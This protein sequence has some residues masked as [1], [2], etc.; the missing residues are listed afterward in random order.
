MSDIPSEPLATSP[1]AAGPAGPNFEGKIGAYFLL[2]LLAQSAPVALAGTT[3]VKV[4]FQRASE[5]FPLDD[6]I[7]HAEHADG[8]AATLQIQAKRTITFA[9]QDTVFKDVVAQVAKAIQEPGFWEGQNELAVATPRTSSKITGSY[10]DVLRWAREIGSSEEFFAR[11]Q[12]PGAANADMRTFVETFRANL[13]EAGAP[14]DDLT[15]WRVLSRFHILIFDFESGGSLAEGYALEHARMLLGPERAAEAGALWSTLFDIAMTKAAA[16]GD[17]NNSTLRDELKKKGI[18][19]GDDR[20]FAPILNTI[21]SEARLALADIGTMVGTTRL[22]RHVHLSKVRDAQDTHRFVIIHG[23]AGV[24][25]SGVLRQLAERAAEDAP[26]L[27]LAPSRIEPKGFL[28]HCRRLG[29]QGT[30]ED[31]L[32]KLAAA[33]SAI[34]FIDNLDRF[35]DDE[36]QTVKDALR[37]ASQL[38]G[39]SVLATARATFGKSDDNWLP[40]EAITALGEASIP[41]TELNEDDLEEIRAAQP[42]LRPLLS[43]THPAKPIVRNLF[44]LSRIARQPTEEDVPTTELAMAA[45]WWQASEGTKST[46][47]ERQRI[48]R[49]AADAVLQGVDVVD[50][51]HQDANAVDDLVRSQTLL[52]RGSD[53]VALRHDVLREWAAANRLIDDYSLIEKLPLTRPASPILARAIELAA[54]SALERQPSTPSWQDI[55]NTVS[56]HSHHPSWRRAALLAIVNS[57]A[58]MDLLVQQS[59]ALLADD[60]K[61]LIEITRAMRAVNVLPAEIVL[62][63]LIARGLVIPKGVFIPQGNSWLPLL[64]WL[65]QSFETLPVLALK[66]V[67]DLFWDWSLGTFGL[68]PLTPYILD[69]IYPVL[70]RLKVGQEFPGQQSPLDALADGQRRALTDSLRNTFIAFCPTR[71]ALAADYLALLAAEPERSLQSLIAEPGELPKAA[72]QPFA[73]LIRSALVTSRSGSRSSRYDAVNPFSYL[74]HSFFP[75][76]DRT[77]AFASLLTHAPAIGLSLIQ[78]LVAYAVSEMAQGTPP[79]DDG[80]PL[81]IDGHNRFFPWLRTYR[82]AR[83]EGSNTVS[84]ALTA[85]RAWAIGRVQKGD[86]INVVISDVLGPPGT[87]AAFV[88][89]AIDVLRSLESLL[90]EAAIP[91]VGSP[92]LLSFERRSS[93]LDGRGPR[94]IL[95]TRAARFNPQRL[96]PLEHILPQ[97]ALPQNADARALLLNQ[98]QDAA[99]RLG[100]P[101]A[102][103]D[104]GDPR[105]MVILAINYINP[106]NWSPNPENPSQSV[107]TSPQDEAQRQQALLSAASAGTRDFAIHTQLHMALE[108]P[109]HSS[110]AFAQGV[111]EWATA[112]EAT[113]D[114]EDSHPN[115]QDR[116]R[117]AFIILRDG[118]DE[119]VQNHGA[120]AV[121]TLSNVASQPRDQLP[122]GQQLPYNDVALAF[123]GLFYAHRRNPS[124]DYIARLLRFAAT[125]PIEAG[126]G[127]TFV[128][129]DIACLDPRLSNALVRTAFAA[130]VRPRRSASFDEAKDEAARVAHT[131]ATEAH[132]LAE[133]A[134]LRNNRAEPSWPSFPIEQARKRRGIRLPS[135]NAANSQEPEPTSEPAET[136]VDER[137]AATWISL[138]YP[139]CEGTYANNVI[140]VMQA[141]QLY[142]TTR[143]GA[144]LEPHADVDASLRGDWSQAYYELIARLIHTLTP[145]QLDAVCRGIT[146]LPESAFLDVGP[147]FLAPLQDRYFSGGGIEAQV[148]KVR[149]EL[150]KRLIETRRWADHVRRS[151]GGIETHLSY[152]IPPLLFGYHGLGTSGTFL[153]PDNIERVLP[154]LPSASAIVSAGPTIFTGGLALSL[155]EIRPDARLLPFAVDVAEALLNAHPTDTVLWNDFSFGPRWCRWLDAM[156]TANPTALAASESMEARV[157]SILGRLASIGV[158]EAATLERKLLH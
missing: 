31:L 1:A 152:A 75:P 102:G 27:V 105:V 58:A 23:D 13:K 30:A 29:F 70:R 96:L 99:Q 112:A 5:G 82:W 123:A 80:I 63:D 127:A 32:K 59:A 107:Y 143:N 120:W 9:P 122:F 158:A 136:F 101:E 85:L 124:Y 17:I 140:A 77:K 55:L 103:S 36:R 115:R 22:A 35:T 145:D 130:S 71:P 18:Q 153:G 41:I 38:P 97:F 126:V 56:D 125:R 25:K 138:L 154:L 135:S 128:A 61:L 119:T 114:E 81:V 90:L 54:R 62:K 50:V 67:S 116:L 146:D 83:E 148:I 133:L 95:P 93:S 142:T 40:E 92:E 108:H 65:I 34:I 141:Y 69:R 72:P 51:A 118:S 111:A 37:V 157:H 33:G 8:K 151:S 49:K 47:R 104:F 21:Q 106:D 20:A 10:Q 7:A 155:V 109:T 134:W 100:L 39:I 139:L 113:S 12:R 131:E 46:S 57:E 19:P 11:L 94:N 66:D 156:H 91:F 43:D 6:T 53:R 2:G 3:I 121:E 84:A 144:G 68:S 60:G 52:D 44:R 137:T 48:L 149:S 24:G 73:D 28:A 117:S 129:N 86:D 42:R 4:A 88:L 16:G 150:A 14:D 78:D 132:V 147:A 89:V 110:Q 26:V 74:D 98:L 79:D 87:C 64:M 76:A 45:H 15:L